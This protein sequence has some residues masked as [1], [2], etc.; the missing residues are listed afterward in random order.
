MTFDPETLYARPAPGRRIHPMVFV[1]AGL[2]AAAVIGGL[3]TMDTWLPGH[4]PVAPGPPPVRSQNSGDGGA[5]L[6]FPSRYAPV[7]YS[8]PPAPEPAPA[9][10]PS[11]PAAQ[12]NPAP[13]G[14]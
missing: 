9:P 4:D 10:P 5:P 14:P 11:A 1:A 8:P 13:A 6:A 12:G 7:A 2:A 3:A